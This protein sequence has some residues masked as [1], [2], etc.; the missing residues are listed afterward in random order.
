LTATRESYI[1]NPVFTWKYN[2]V[3]VGTGNPY[4]LPGGLTAATAGKYTCTVTEGTLT[5]EEAVVNVMFTDPPAPTIDGKLHYCL[6]EQFEQITI[7]GT[8]PK[9]YYIPSGGSPLPVA[10]TINTSSPNSLTYYVTQTVNGCESSERTLVNF[11]AARKPAVPIVTTPVYYCEEAPADQLYAF[12][13]NL[14]WYYSPV[15]TIHTE[16]APTPNTSKL[17]SLEY[18]VTQTVNGCESDRNKIDVVV[19]FKPNGLILANKKELCAN[20]ELTLGYYGSADPTSQYNWI[21]PDK[22]TTIMNGGFDQGPLVIRLDTPGQFQVKLRVGNTGCLSDEYTQNIS[23]KPLP[24]ANIS[25][26]SD[27]C[28]DQ[29]I[30]IA[31]D[32]YTKGLRSFDWDFDGGLI[33][34]EAT[35]QGAHGVYWATAGTKNIK[36]TVEDKG[37]TSVTTE[38]VTVHPKPDATI[39][40]QN[41]KEGD[42]ICASDSL[43]VSVGVIEPNAA[44]KWSPERFFDSY[45]NDAVTYARVDFDSRIYVEVEDIYGCTNKDSMMVTTKPCCEMSFPTAFTPNGDSRNDLFRP[46]TVGN[47]QVKTFRIV[48][49]YGQAVFETANAHTGWDGTMNGKPADI[50]TYFYLISFNCGNE[51]INQSG[52]VILVR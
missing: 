29:D 4:N 37:C 39:T 25:A 16:T 43:K 52:E 21:L 12:G 15:S 33:S 8:D 18:F 24:Y 7:N 22:G 9:W 48:N 35:G 6:N 36:V 31:S 20:E 49:R 1:N 51:T 2:G 23:V 10:P 34:H 46:I 30:L 38:T 27:A 44:Y 14:K 13:D 11:T 3:T 17:Q 50:G 47:R 19:T 42:V 32:N 45:S 41:Y 26:K 40:A 28:V 5:S